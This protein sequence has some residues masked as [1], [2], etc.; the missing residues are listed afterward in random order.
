[1]ADHFYSL[2]AGPAESPVTVIATGTSTQ[3]GTIELRTH[4]GASLTRIDVLKALEALEGYFS[5]NNAPTP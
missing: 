2:S 4:D 1:M 5:M 3:G